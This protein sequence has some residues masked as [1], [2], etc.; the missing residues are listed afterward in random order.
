MQKAY[1]EAL[2]D[3]REDIHSFC[4]KRGADYVTLNTDVPIEKVL[5][6]ELLK[7]GIME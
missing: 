4:M 7:V 6:G 3:F 2:H 5:F 1:E